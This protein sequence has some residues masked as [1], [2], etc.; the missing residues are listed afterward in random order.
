VGTKKVNISLY[1]DCYPF[2]VGLCSL[3]IERQR[4]GKSLLFGRKKQNISQRS[5]YGVGQ[6][7]ECWFRLVFLYSDSVI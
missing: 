5:E 7:A 2:F 3:S 6:I 1:L 4:Q